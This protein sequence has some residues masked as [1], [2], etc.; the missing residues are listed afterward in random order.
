MNKIKI[1]SETSNDF[2]VLWYEFAGE[3]HFWCQW[4]ISAFLNLLHSAG[5]SRKDNM[6]GL[7]IGCGNGLIIKQLEKN[8]SW[9][10]DGVD[11]NKTGLEQ[12]ISNRG[13]I[14]QYNIHDQLK[15]MENTYDFLVLFD[16]LEHIDDT[17]AFLES[18]LFHLK[19]GGYL[20]INVPAINLLWSGY[21]QKVGHLRRYDKQMMSET[22]KPFNLSIVSMAY[23]GLSM[24]P[25]LCVRKLVMGKNMSINDTVKTGFDPPN[26]FSHTFLKI[27]MKLETKLLKKPVLGTSLMAIARKA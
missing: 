3:E 8:T 23:W 16:I 7:D 21:D 13:H 27:L 26:A 14:M 12:C 1:L 11:L 6:R 22:V 18:A 9:S 24:L 17:K 5:I 19:P 2:P 25:L 10:I 20:L 15:E 4:R